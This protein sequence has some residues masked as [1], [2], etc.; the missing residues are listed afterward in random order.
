[1]S[2][3]RV[4]KRANVTAGLFLVKPLVVL[5][6]RL[7]GP[8]PLRLSMVKLAHNLDGHDLALVVKPP[9]ESYVEATPVQ[10]TSR[11]A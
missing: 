11:A 8:G 1:M 4:M 7:L 2:P 3:R 6:A 10:P 9:L 5:A